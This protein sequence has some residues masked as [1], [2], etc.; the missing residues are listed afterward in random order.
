MLWL[1]RFCGQLPLPTSAGAPATY[2]LGQARVSIVWMLVV[3]DLC[4]YRYFLPI[5]SGTI[6]AATS[7]S[8]KLTAP[9]EGSLFHWLLHSLQWVVVAFGSLPSVDPLSVR[10][11]PAS[12]PL[13]EPFSFSL[14]LGRGGA[15]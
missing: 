2:P 8:A 11:S 10:H 15:R 14:A 12:S 4:L 7:Q 3:D 6:R 13:G 9:L 1:L 5:C